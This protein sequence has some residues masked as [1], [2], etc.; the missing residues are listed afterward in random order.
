MCILLDLGPKTS[1]WSD[2]MSVDTSVKTT[3]F[4]PDSIV[5]VVL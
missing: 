5:T 3:I 2:L 4:T 1:Q